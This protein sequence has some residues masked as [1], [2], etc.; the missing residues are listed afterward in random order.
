MVH[1]TKRKN[2]DERMKARARRLAERDAKRA[3]AL[4]GLHDRA[5]AS[6]NEAAAES[7]ARRL[8]KIFGVDPELA[9]EAARM[10]VDRPL[11][12]PEDPDVAAWLERQEAARKNAGEGEPPPASEVDTKPDR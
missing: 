7:I 11:G 5:L 12:K 6:G 4:R 1:V 8:N 2:H 3:D 9:M 10:E